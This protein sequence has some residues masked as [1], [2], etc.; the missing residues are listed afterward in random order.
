MIHAAPAVLVKSL[1][2]SSHA[3]T[4]AA[5]AS[6]LFEPKRKSPL[7]IFLL[8]ST[9]LSFS[10]DCADFFSCDFVDRV[11]SCKTIHEIT[12]MGLLLTAYSALLTSQCLIRFAHD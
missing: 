7:A 4:G 2:D 11:L 12:R 5:I 1:H 10:T 6:R 3:L 8:Q 9:S